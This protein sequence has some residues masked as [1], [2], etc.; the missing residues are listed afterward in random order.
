LGQQI[1][2]PVKKV[3]IWLWR[4]I[5]RHKHKWIEEDMGT[6]FLGHFRDIP[7]THLSIKELKKRK[8]WE[9]C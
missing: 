8:E 3:F 2:L 5:G 9:K 7:F 6:S 4:M 1:D